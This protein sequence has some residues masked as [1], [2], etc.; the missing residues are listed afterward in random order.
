VFACSV[1]KT[2]PG[3]L[4]QKIL[5]KHDEPHTTQIIATGASQGTWT[6][7]FYDGVFGWLPTASLAPLPSKPV[8]TIENWLG[9]YRQGKDTPSIKND[10]LLLTKGKLP[11]TIH[12]SGRGYWYGINDV[13]HF[14]EINADAI[15]YGRFLHVVDGEGEGACVLDLALDPSTH[16][17]A[18]NDNSNCGGMNVRFWG[19]WTRFTPSN[20]HPK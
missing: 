8:A 16:T 5:P 10:R 14:G 9:W 13:V 15:P 12:V 19:M 1:N 20:S 11:G 7:V 6:C 3:C 2:N 4:A 18:A 17:L